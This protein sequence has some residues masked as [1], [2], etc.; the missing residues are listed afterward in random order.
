MNQRRIWTHH[1][2]S[3]FLFDLEDWCFQ[4][5]KYHCFLHFSKIATTGAI[6][7]VLGLQD[8]YNF[9]GR[10]EL[11][12]HDDQATK[13]QQPPRQAWGG[14]HG[15]NS[16]SNP[17]EAVFSAGWKGEGQG[18]GL[19]PPFSPHEA[20]ESSNLFPADQPFTEHLLCVFPKF[21]LRQLTGLMKRIYDSSVLVW[22]GV[23]IKLW[24]AFSRGRG[25]LEDFLWWVVSTFCCLS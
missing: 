15:E 11:P 20:W 8:V 25:R 16:K 22:I 24:L 6:F 14:S 18:I 7:P 12:K 17:V 19:K 13:Q 9:F 5:Q 3:R 2:P 23:K 21:L 4:R 10:E 1:V